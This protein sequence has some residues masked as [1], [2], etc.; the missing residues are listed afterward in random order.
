MNR[1]E[2][3]MA[4][5]KVS[6][7]VL[8]SMTDKVCNEARYLMENFTSNQFCEQVLDALNDEEQL[9]IYLDKIFNA[10][11]DCFTLPQLKILDKSNEDSGNYH[12]MYK[13]LQAY[14]KAITDDKKTYNDN[15]FYR[16][17]NDETYEILFRELRDTVAEP[18]P[19]TKKTWSDVERRTLRKATDYDKIQDLFT[20]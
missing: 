1:Q 12:L 15:Y 16:L 20:K 10:L 11:Q 7:D 14:F 13:K 3:I 9:N 6:A 8:L 4:Q 18:H 19:K 17:D 5:G 2:A